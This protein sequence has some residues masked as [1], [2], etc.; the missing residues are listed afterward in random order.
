MGNIDTK[1]SS[2]TTPYYIVSD[3]DEYLN[4]DSNSIWLIKRANF[5]NECKNATLFEFNNSNSKTDPPKTTKQLTFALNQIKVILKKL[6][7]LETI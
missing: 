4:T 7:S 5:N 1:L 3:K 6:N 2:V